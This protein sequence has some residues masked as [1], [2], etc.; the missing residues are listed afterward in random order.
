ML[1]VRHTRI[2]TEAFGVVLVQ[3]LAVGVAA[4]TSTTG[5]TSRFTLCLRTAHPGALVS[6]SPAVSSLTEGPDTP[7][8][9]ECRGLP[10]AAGGG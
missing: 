3:Q 8:E 1:D 10:G 5:G 9:S 6:A 7:G 4:C 2:G